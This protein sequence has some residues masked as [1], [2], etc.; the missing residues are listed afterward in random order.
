MH[1]NAHFGGHEEVETFGS[2]QRGLSS[3][4]KFQRQSRPQ[5]LLEREL[6]ANWSRVV[7]KPD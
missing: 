6:S 4:K 7:L 2:K 3:C 1:V 5:D